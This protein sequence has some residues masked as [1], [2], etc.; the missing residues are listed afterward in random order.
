MQIK[1]GNDLLNL[2][3]KYQ[4]RI[5]DIILKYEHQNT[6]K[7]TDEIK[8]RMK[9]DFAVMKISAKKALVDPEEISPKIIQNDAKKLWEKYVKGRSIC[10]P[11]LTKAMIYALSAT[12]VNASMGKIV[13]APT[14]GACGVI[15]GALIALMEEKNRDESEII[16]G[17]FTAAGIGLVIAQNASL[18]GAIG[19]CQSEIGSACAMASAAITEIMGGSAEMCLHASALALKSMMGLVCD[20]VASLV[21]APCSKRNATAVMTAFGCAEMALAGIESVIP[22]DEVVLAMA[23]V[24]RD[25]PCSLKETSTGGIAATPTALSIQKELFGN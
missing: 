19:G 10:S 12:E 5:S 9:N 13:T 4:S 2:C 14:A 18:A 22:F 15:P 7:S 8:E 16:Q 17:L 20:P 3:I 24:G 25:M 11:M 21:E 6:A 23:Q 1:S